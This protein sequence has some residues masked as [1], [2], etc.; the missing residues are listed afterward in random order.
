MPASRPLRSLLGTAFA[1]TL[2]G[3]LWLRLHTEWSLGFFAFALAL[4]A[5]AVAAPRLFAPVQAA[6]DRFGRAVAAVLTVLILGLLF[7]VVFVPGRL[8]LAML[9][10][11]PLH[12]RPDPARASYWEPLSP[13]GPIDRFRRQY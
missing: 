9:R 11:D 10:R 6:L 12:R 13:A 2:T 8:V 7:L 3:C 4:F 5:L 1:A